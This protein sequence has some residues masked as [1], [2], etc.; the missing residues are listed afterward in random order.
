MAM[1]RL[2]MTAAHVV[3]PRTQSV[4]PSG[5]TC[6]I[7]LD[8]SGSRSHSQLHNRVPRYIEQRFWALADEIRV[9]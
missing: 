1:L 8:G 3:H 7:S 9:K 6:R 2:L 4:C 5:S